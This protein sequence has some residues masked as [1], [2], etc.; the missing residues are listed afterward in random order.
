MACAKL[1]HDPGCWRGWLGAHGV[2]WLCVTLLSWYDDIIKWKHFPHYWPFVWRIHRSPVNSPHKCQWRGAL[3]FYFD[4]RLNKRFSKQS[5][6]WW[7]EMALRS[8][9]CHCNGKQRPTPQPN[10][11]TVCQIFS[12][13]LFGMLQSHQVNVLYII[14]V[15]FCSIVALRWQ[16]LDRTI[17]Y[18][19]GA[20]W[21]LILKQNQPH[22]W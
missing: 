6:H 18:F 19:A 11:I 2:V 4:Q 12:V 13:K 16:S 5:W 15:R 17:W 22:G 10:C 21:V 14:W 20:T 1:W 3:T 7:F 8:L 9:W